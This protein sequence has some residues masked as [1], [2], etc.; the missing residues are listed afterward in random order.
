MPKPWE[1]TP[2]EAREI[3]ARLRDRHL[4]ADRVAAPLLFQQLLESDC[5]CAE[6]PGAGNSNPSTSGA[7]VDR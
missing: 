1:V 3:G 5:L 2:E 4:E 7:L 6:A